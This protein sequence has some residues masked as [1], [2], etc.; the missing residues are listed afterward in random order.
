MTRNYDNMWNERQEITAIEL[1]MRN[2]SLQIK[3]SFSKI[4]PA[5]FC[6]A[7]FYSTFIHNFVEKTHPTLTLVRFQQ[8]EKCNSR[9]YKIFLQWIHQMKKCS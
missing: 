6:L 9:N 7:L 3:C 2:L 8:L 5:F 1:K 4:N